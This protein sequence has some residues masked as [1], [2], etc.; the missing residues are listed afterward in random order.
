MS[1][2]YSNN[3]MVDNYEIIYLHSFHVPNIKKET[4][5][6]EMDSESGTFGG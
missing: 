4:G 2:Y 5:K 6:L 3:T 1:F